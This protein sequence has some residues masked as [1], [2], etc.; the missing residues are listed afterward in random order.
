MSQQLVDFAYNWSVNRIKL[1]DNHYDVPSKQAYRLRPSR[2]GRLAYVTAVEHL[3]HL[4]GMENTVI[5][6][7]EY[8]GRQSDIFRTGHDKEALIVQTMRAT[9]ITLDYQVPCTF[10]LHGYVIEGTADLVVDDTVVDI[11]TASASNY[12]R[13]LTGYN[14]LTY[15]TQLALY[16]HALHLESTALFL[17]NKDTSEVTYQRINLTTEFNRVSD[18]LLHLRTMEE[19]PSLEQA[20][21]YLVE[22]FLIP[23]PPSQMRNKTATG[24][25]LLPPELRYEPNVLNVL[26]E[27]DYGPSDTV[28]VTGVVADP[29]TRIR[30]TYK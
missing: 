4:Y 14:T 1:P 17:Y 19:L 7:T 18:I 15:R 13:L 26:W 5:D 11:K 24:I 21:S 10:N 23:E 8:Y 20:W 30:N 9:G 27:T 3:V 16:A 6:N 29:C 22:H 12:K 2:L 28:H 25:L